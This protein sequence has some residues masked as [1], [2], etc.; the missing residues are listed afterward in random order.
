[1]EAESLS[2]FTSFCLG[3]VKRSLLL[4]KCDGGGAVWLAVAS[5]VTVVVTV[6]VITVLWLTQ[7]F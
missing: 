2:L 5:V 3:V 1:M 6:V 7:A 4:E